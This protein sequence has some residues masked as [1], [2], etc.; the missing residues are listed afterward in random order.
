MIYFFDARDRRLKILV[1]A[2]QFR[3][4]PLPNEAFSDRKH[5]LLRVEI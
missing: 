4:W 3:L 2:V 1:S 5:Q